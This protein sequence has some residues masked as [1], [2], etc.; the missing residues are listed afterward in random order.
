MRKINKLDVLRLVLVLALVAGTGLAFGSVG[1]FTPT[2]KIT[3]AVY[4][5][6][7][8]PEQVAEL[9]ATTHLLHFAGAV[10]DAYVASHTG[11]QPLPRAQAISGGCTM[12]HNY[13]ENMKWWGVA[14]AAIVPYETDNPLPVTDIYGN[15]VSPY[16]L[17]ST[18]DWVLNLTFT[19]DSLASIP[20]QPGLDVYQYSKSGTNYSRVDYLW[21][22][23]SSLS[24]GPVSVQYINASTGAVSGCGTAEKGLC[25]IAEDAVGMAAGGSGA[26]AKQE[27]P[28][29]N[30][31]YHGA[32]VFYTHEMAFTT[33]QYAAKPVKLCGAC[34]VFKLPP[35]MWGGEPWAGA[36]IKSYS[37]AGA[38]GGN[39]EAL[40]SGDPFGFTPNYDQSGFISLMR[41]AK[42][43]SVQYKTP[44][45]AHANVP[46]LR[47][48][49]H[50]GVNGETV[51][52][53]KFQ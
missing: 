29:S 31:S 12:C 37:A 47:C 4:C 16:G 45:W 53:N 41:G 33:A 15:V 39:V 43:L 51:S 35:M 25:H 23:L 20:W 2:H 14:N 32:G 18:Q 40:P 3:E 10:S 8:H 26:F 36:G 19:T 13:W 46:C 24:P 52:N 9:N 6:S 49:A 7:C 38:L 48:H 27:F 1:R 21:S 22:A 17:A 11:A 30:V 28:D 34:H 44:D 42:Q 5:G 50:A